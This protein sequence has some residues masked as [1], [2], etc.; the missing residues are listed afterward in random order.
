MATATGACYVGSWIGIA[1][2]S[3]HVHVEADDPVRGGTTIISFHVP[4]E[5]EKGSI[6]TEVTVLLPDLASARTDVMAGWTA[7]LDKDPS[8]GT[9][10]SVTWTA[11]PDAGI[12]SDQFEVFQMQ[13]TLPDA[14]HA[15]FPAIQTYADGTVVRWDQ[16]TVPGADEPS[17][18]APKLTLVEGET[19]HTEHA[20]NAPETPPRT[21]ID[22]ESEG[23]AP[24]NVARALSGAALLLAAIGLG[25]A[26]V[27]RGA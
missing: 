26:F 13:V 4:N 14:E 12:L 21:P 7:R 20:P 25:V 16:L 6:T 23:L 5:S 22:Q 24:D 27:R 15:A 11:D 18:P 8:A 1:P 17:H 3:A 9:A 2:A 10:Q 19:S